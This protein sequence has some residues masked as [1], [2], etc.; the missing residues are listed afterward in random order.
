MAAPPRMVVACVLCLGAGL[1]GGWLMH[2]QR[3]VAP[4]AGTVA[5][6]AAVQP[7]AVDGTPTRANRVLDLALMRAVV[8]EEL[9]SALAAS[10][11]GAAPASA[12]ATAQSQRDEPA[13]A[14]PPSAAYQ[15]ARAQVTTG[16]Q[17]GN[18]TEGSRRELSSILGDM[19][20]Q[21]RDEVIRDVIRA[22][23]EGKLKVEIDGP[24]FL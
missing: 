21:E 17:R 18:W 5:P 10:A 20:P 11:Q 19:S 6:E 24:L 1:G 8:H 16:L 9:Q 13:E 7:E 2:R 12:M 22:S 3:G 14:G 4:P 15:Q 23:N